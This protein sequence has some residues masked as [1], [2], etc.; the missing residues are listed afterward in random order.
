MPGSHLR[1]GAVAELDSEQENAG[2]TM[3]IAIF[4]GFDPDGRFLLE[5]ADGESTLVALSTIGL[6]RS[7]IGA[8]VAI[9]HVH[10][11]PRP[12]IVGRLLEKAS[13]EAP[14][15]RVDGER[16]VLQAKR[17]IELRCGDASIVLTRAGK[18][19]I[20]GAYVLSRSRGANKVKGAFV[21]IN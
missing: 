21:D 1:H 8:R 4:A 6:T 2:G 7:D 15:V 18:I 13:A 17:Q 19:L 20:R 3:K 12:I 16:L 9:A 5:R 14:I 11:D 10:G